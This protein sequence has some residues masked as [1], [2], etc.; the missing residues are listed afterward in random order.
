MTPSI[1]P[2]ALLAAAMTIPAASFASNANGDSKLSGNATPNNATAAANDTLVN[3]VANG[4]EPK[5]GAFAEIRGQITDNN[6]NPISEAT[7]SVKGMKRAVRTKANGKFILSELPSGE[8]TILVHAIGYTPQ[9]RT[10]KLSNN[11]SYEGIDFV[12]QERSDALPTVDVMGRREQ[13]YKNSVSFVGT[14]TATALKDVPQSIGYVTKELVLDQGAITVN[15]VVKNISGVNQYS[16][17]NDFS[18][19]GFR[20]L[21]NLNSGNLLNGMRGL[22]PLFRQSS[23]ANIE[24]VE[25]IK[26]PA[27]ALFGNAAPGGVVNRVTKKPLDVARRSVSLTAGSFNTS[28]V[29]GDFTGPLN[30]KKSL[31]YRLNLGYENTDGFRDLQGLTTFIVAP[32]FTYILSDR[33]QLNADITYNNN[34]GKLDRGLAIHGDGDLFSV[35]FNSTQSAASDFMSENTFNLSFALSHQ[36]AK[37]LLFNSTYLYSSYLENTEEHAQQHA[38]QSTIDGKQDFSKVEMRFEKRHRH[39]TSN[40]FN[41]YLSWYFATGALK[42]KLLLGYDYF[43]T[44][45]APGLSS[46]SASGYLL[47]NGTVV[48]KFDVKK[49]DD[50]QLDASGNP[51]TNVPS[52]DLNSTLGN[53]I[54]DVTKYIYKTGAGNPNGQGSAVR[55]YSNGVYLQEQLRWGRLQT[56]LSARVEWFT[57]VTKNAKGIEKKTTQTAFIPRVGLVYA[58]TPSTNV[59]ASWIRGFEPQS[60]AIQSDPE[61]GGPFDPMKSELWEVGAKG[62]YLNKRLSVTTSVFRIRKNNSLYSAGDPVNPKLR[63]AVGEEVSR[64][65]EF[66]VSG[67]ILPYWSITANYSYNIAEITKAAPG[68]KDLNIQRPGTPRHAANLWTKFIIPS[69]ALRNLGM[70]LGINGVSAREGQVGRRAQLVTY[71]GYSLLNLALY[72]KVRDMQL[73]LNWNNVLNKQYYI[74]GFDRFRSFPGAPSNI[75]LTATYRF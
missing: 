74:S 66:D 31:L 39:I 65:V 50:Y 47:K 23:L 30:E 62:E 60:V 35:P 22:T 56:L 49:K 20:S 34:M 67:R 1:I 42:H 40:N 73:Q 63:V 54:Q 8:S 24:R 16:A 33:T 12:L 46:L 25:V 44:A 48:D 51:R 45:I 29:Y 52:F 55:S 36:L 38:Y 71:P 26:G 7:I 58:L 4:T 13:S 2:V 32:S 75:N 9:Q 70:G 3:R 68:T 10:I 6:G 27:S 64:G 5:Q 61:T 28:N 72:Y 59:Y 41:N 17:Y 18:I 14:K 43:N 15:D 69:G 37:G 53:R 21:G 19:R 11:K 57:D